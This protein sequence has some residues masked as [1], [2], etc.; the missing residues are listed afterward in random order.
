V[1]IVFS[2]MV[3][4]DPGQGGAS[5]AILQYVLGLR[6]LGHE[7]LLVEPVE[8]IRDRAAAYFQRH[9]VQRFSL[10]GRAA[11][12]EDGTGETVGVPYREL[13]R[14]ADG[15]DL[16]INVSG[17]LRDPGLRSRP[18]QVYLDLDPVFNDK[19][20]QIF[21]YNGLPVV[22]DKKSILY[23]EGVTVDFH[24]DLN[25]RGFSISNPSAKSTCGCGSSFSM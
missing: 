21:E 2:G 15:A 16:L 3:A 9:I 4:G 20:D 13:A 12:L 8:R 11:L 6:A 1:R 5:W 18:M 19:I 17:M 23:L 10:D 14:F 25:R 7:V 22:V 24:D